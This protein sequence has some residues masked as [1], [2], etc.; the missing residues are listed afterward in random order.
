VTLRVQA[1]DFEKRINA[2]LRMLDPAEVASDRSDREF[3]PFFSELF[4][5]SPQFS[6]SVPTVEVAREP[7]LIARRIQLETELARARAELKVCESL[8]GESMKEKAD[9]LRIDIAGKEAQRESIA[10]MIAQTHDEVTSLSTA[11]ET[12]KAELAAVDA[13]VAALRL[14]QEITGSTL[15]ENLPKGYLSTQ[16]GVEGRDLPARMD[17]TVVASPSLPTARLRRSA[18]WVRS[19]PGLSADCWRVLSW[20]WRTWSSSCRKSA[21]RRRKRVPRGSRT[22]ACPRDKEDA[23]GW[24]GTVIRGRRSF[25]AES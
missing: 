4:T 6:V 24:R 2:L 10:S 19:R 8:G 16:E 1:R 17:F 14:Q 22:D 23:R 11:L 15:A 3:R 25:A 13:E 5:N 9:G 18:W 12:V 7:G 20:R 21:R